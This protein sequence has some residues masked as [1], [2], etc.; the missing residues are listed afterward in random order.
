MATWV[1]CGFLA[2]DGEHEA[3]AIRVGPRR[4]KIP[5]GPCYQTT[6]AVEVRRGAGVA[7]EAVG[8][9]VEPRQAET[10]IRTDRADLVILER[11]MPCSP[12]DKALRPTA[13]NGRR[14]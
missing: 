7:M 4:T 10:I 1:S 14:G 2:L 3:T 13:S 11:E 8:M 5:V 12:E 6:F 9:I